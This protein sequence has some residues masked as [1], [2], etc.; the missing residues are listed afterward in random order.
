[1]TDC[2]P[3]PEQLNAYVDG[4]LPAAEMAR[5]ARAIADDRVIAERIALLSRLKAAVQEATVGEVTGVTT[6]PP[7]LSFKLPAIAAAIAFAL[8]LAGSTLL[9]LWPSPGNPSALAQAWSLHAEWENN[10]GVPAEPPSAGLL[11]AA[12]AELGPSAAVPD[13]SAAKLKLRHAT[14]YGDTGGRRLLHAG[15]SGTRGCQVSL[16]VT[17][18]SSGLAT[19]V[20]DYGQ[21]PEQAYGWRSGGLGYL[22]LARGMD[23]ARLRLI[24]AS[25]YKAV[26]EQ[27]PLGPRSQQALAKSRAESRPCLS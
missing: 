27:A 12:L 4:E 24:A 3:S 14:L 10:P 9:H 22:V 11:L 6:P 25:V 16:F 21:G 18:A 5:V 2:N 19:E 13:L 1:M 7:P 15:Y 23:P 8:F 20:T 26:R 17:E